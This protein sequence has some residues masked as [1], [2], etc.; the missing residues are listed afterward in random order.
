MGEQS[1]QITV[2]S[3]GPSASF[4]SVQDDRQLAPKD[5]RR[6]HGS[7]R[8][9]LDRRLAGENLAVKS[10]GANQR[11]VGA[12]LDDAA[13]LQDEDLMCVLHGRKPMRD[14]EGGAAP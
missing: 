11:G 10:S 5:S 2:K 6:Q 4:H 1:R 13:L 3:R 8:R 7:L 9:S 12:S 14:D